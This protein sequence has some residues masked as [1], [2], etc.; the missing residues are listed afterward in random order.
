MSKPATHFIVTANFTD[1]GAVA[2]RRADGSWSRS[3][4]E[5]GIFPTEAEATPCVDSAAKNEQRLVADPYAIDV[6]VGDGGIEA[7]TARERI[8]ANGPT[9]PMRRPDSGVTRKPA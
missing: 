2:Y 9:I 6:H 8:R 1:D 5:A 7:L 4:A 3:L